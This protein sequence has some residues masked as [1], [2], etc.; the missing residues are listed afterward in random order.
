MGMQVTSC[1]LGHCHFLPEHEQPLTRVRQG[2]ARSTWEIV[3]AGCRVGFARRSY[4]RY[5]G[6]AKRVLR[7]VK[8][9]VP[10]KQ[11]GTRTFLASDPREAVRGGGP[12]PPR[13]P[14]PPPPTVHVV[15]NITSQ[16][17]PLARS[18]T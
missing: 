6:S 15:N 13:H 2:S 16:A 10:P 11:Y 12:P 18:F 8:L 5:S 9:Y 14:P 3:H 1:N 7:K 4:I 17:T